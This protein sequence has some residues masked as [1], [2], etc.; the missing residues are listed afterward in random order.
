MNK[1]LFCAL[2][3]VAGAS[4]AG[5]TLY[6]GSQSED[7]YAQLIQQLDQMSG[8]SVAQET[9][10]PGFLE[11]EGITRV[12]MTDAADSPVLFRLK[13]QIYHSPVNLD[14]EGELVNASR[15]VTTL[16][17]D[18][19]SDEGQQLVMLFTDKPV[20]LTT[21]IGFDGSSNN[22]MDVSAFR[23]DSDELTME[24]APTQ[25]N[26]SFDS[27]GLLKGTGSIGALTL[28]VPDAFD[29]SMEP[30]TA[31]F[32]LDWARDGVYVGTQN[33]KLGKMRM[34]NAMTGMETILDSATLSSISSVNEERFSTGMTFD[35]NIVDPMIPVEHVRFSTDI[36]NL[37]MNGFSQYMSFAAKLSDDEAIASDPIAFMSEM[38]D[39]YKAIFTPGSGLQYGLE[40]NNADGAVK[41]STSVI[42]KGDG[43]TSGSENIATVGD[44]IAAMTGKL[45]I[46]ADLAALAMTPLPILLND[47]SMAQWIVN[48]GE[49]VKTR[50]S[51]ED[52]IIDING[53][54]LPLEMMLGDM[55][56]TPLDLS[57]LAE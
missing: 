16:V 54:P 28:N 33:L 37:D 26:F 21:H 35:T 45:D 46:D 48:D 34:S 17:T 53:N 20:M 42:F 51:V 23:L 40:L 25:Y 27:E 12:S 24:S 5:T 18:S 38:V 13:H 36:D 31:A 44:L 19:L 43:S 22:V 57:Q 9:W 50:I 47:P 11:S 41:A 1:W 30:G 4:W 8:L 55:L 29:L 2:P 6:S 10:Q 39:V 15:V 52:M 32:D 7:A 14:G 3:L 49:T 56:Q